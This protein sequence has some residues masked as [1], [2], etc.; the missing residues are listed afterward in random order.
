MDINLGNL[1]APA[2]ALIEKISDAV[3]GIAKPWQIVRE[4]NAEAEAALIRAEAQVKVSEIQ[5]RALQRFLV[6]EGIKQ[7]N[8]ESIAENAIPLL[9]DQA[10]PAALDNDWIAHFFDRAR[11]ISDDKMQQ[12]WCTVLAGEANAPGS[13]SKRTINLLSDLDKRDAELFQT[14]ARFSWESGGLT[15]L[16][17]DEEAEICAR[18]NVTFATL[19]HLQSLG[20]IYVDVTAGFRIPVEAKRFFVAYHGRAVVLTLPVKERRLLFDIG[21]VALTRSGQELLRVCKRSPIEGCF[22]A[23]VAWWQKHGF[24]PTIHPAP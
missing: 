7:T 9:E 19:S 17:Y 4:A 23:N 20:L 2:T 8:I 15:P 6:E 16:V 22:E 3:G 5:R 14:V 1:T 12:L 10:N 13:F 11:L 24:S 18:H 21:R